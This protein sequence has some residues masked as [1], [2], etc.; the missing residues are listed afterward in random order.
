VSNNIWIGAGR[1][2][3][4]SIGR[5]IINNGQFDYFFSKKVGQV[6]KFGAF[7][8]FH[9][10]LSL[11]QNIEYFFTY[12]ILIFMQFDSFPELTSTTYVLYDM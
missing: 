4:S 10:I 2:Y 9:C 8:F 3:L 7:L 1:Y 11:E 5:K 12:S 6:V